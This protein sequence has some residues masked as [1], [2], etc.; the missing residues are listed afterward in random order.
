MTLHARLTCRLPLALL[1]PAG[2]KLSTFD[3]AKKLLAA[4][5]RAY[6]EEMAK[7]MAAAGAA[8]AK[9]CCQG[10]AVKQVAVAAV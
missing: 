9:P 3:A 5:E 10:K 4:G 7:A 6:Q 2:V 1:L 8:P